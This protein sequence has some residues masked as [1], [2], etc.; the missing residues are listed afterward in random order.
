MEMGPRKAE[1]RWGR[2]DGLWDRMGS[3]WDMEGAGP[4]GLDRRQEALM[5]SDES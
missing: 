5:W 3:R 1:G 4:G 2:R